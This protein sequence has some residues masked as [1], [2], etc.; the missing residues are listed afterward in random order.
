MEEISISGYV[1]EIKKKSDSILIRIELDNKF[2][3][4]EI[5]N[6]ILKL[7][8]LNSSRVGFSENK[9]EIKAGPIS[10]W[11]DEVWEKT[12]Q[13]IK[14]EKEN[15]NKLRKLECENREFRNE[16]DQLTQMIKSLQINQNM[17]GKYNILTG[18]SYVYNDYLSFDSEKNSRY[19][20]PRGRMRLEL[21]TYPENVGIQSI[22]NEFVLFI[23]NNPNKF[24][25][26]ISRDF[27]FHSPNLF[28]RISLFEIIN[29]KEVNIIPEKIKN[30][31]SFSMIKLLDSFSLTSIY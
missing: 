21:K 6:G 28:T 16:I 14:L 27:Y 7:I 12:N 11:L 19:F 25:F 26:S 9:L 3:Q 5:Q 18:F 1:F 31:N 10:I 29:G 20:E 8:N 4:T 30:N 22:D 24:R 13:T 15:Q 2:Y 17:P 23:N